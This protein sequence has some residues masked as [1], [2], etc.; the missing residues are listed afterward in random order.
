MDANTFKDYLEKRGSSVITQVLPNVL[1]KEY[2]MSLLVKTESFYG[3][4]QVNVQIVK[5]NP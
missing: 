4:T 1:N 3:K 2:E 5:I